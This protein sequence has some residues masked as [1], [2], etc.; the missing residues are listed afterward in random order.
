MTDTVPHRVAKP[1]LSPVEEWGKNWFKFKQALGDDIYGDF[2]QWIWIKLLLTSGIKCLLYRMN[3]DR[4]VKV[5]RDYTGHVSQ[6]V[7]FVAIGLVCVVVLFYFI[8]LHQPIIIER[9][10]N[11]DAKDENTQEAN[12]SVVDGEPQSCLWSSFHAGIVV[13]LATMILWNYTRT[14][15]VSPGVALPSQSGDGSERTEGMTQISDSNAPISS[16]FKWR[17]VETRGGCCYLSPILSIKEERCRVALYDGA[18][19]ED[20]ASSEGIVYIPS[21]QTSYCGKCRMN[22]PPR[23]H[24]CSS[25][26]RCVLQVS[27]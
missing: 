6:L 26:N 22:R 18:G 14:V 8:S 4:T 2:N 10:C 19:E 7:P 5:G 23:C 21:P 16:P 12:R 25:C 20:W 13:Y 27:D 9:W 11:C 17:S 15:F 3:L 1:Q 24:H